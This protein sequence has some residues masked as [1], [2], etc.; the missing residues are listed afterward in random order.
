MEGIVLN[1][2]QGLPQ[3]ATFLKRRLAEVFIREFLPKFLE[4]FLIEDLWATDSV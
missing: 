3:P 2:V 4:Q 1:K